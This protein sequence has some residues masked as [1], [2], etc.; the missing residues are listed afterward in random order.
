LL[1]NFSSA[2]AEV[3]RITKNQVGKR[4]VNT[5]VPADD[6]ARLGKLL[7]ELAKLKKTGASKPTETVVSCGNA[8]VS[9][10]QSAENMKAKFVALEE[11]VDLAA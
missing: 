10:E 3:V 5:S 9:A 1:F 2:V 4:F 8:T 11:Q 6:L 7:T